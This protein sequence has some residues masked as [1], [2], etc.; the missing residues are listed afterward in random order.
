MVPA[1]S[2]GISDSLA[3]VRDTLTG[4]GSGG[5]YIYSADVATMI[6][7]Q[8]CIVSGNGYT[9]GNGA[10]IE[11]TYP[12]NVVMTQNAVYNNAG[13][14]IE[15]TNGGTGNCNLEGVNAPVINSVTS[16]G[17]NQYQI[18]F[19]LPSGQCSG[20][21]K[22]EFFVNSPG[23]DNEAQFTSPASAI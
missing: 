19:T 16:L 1:C 17:N 22:V 18:Q 12:D 4:N 6:T 10:G 9:S 14:G 11:I 7:V 21:C 8:Q 15:L 2:G 23:G 5:I 13:Q 3:F 20:N